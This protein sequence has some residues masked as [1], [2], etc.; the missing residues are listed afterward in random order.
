MAAS[1]EVRKP[2]VMTRDT[3]SAPAVVEKGARPSEGEDGRDGGG[4]LDH[5]GG[6]AGGAG[7][8]VDGDEVGPGGE[9]DLEIGLDVAGGELDP[10]GFAAGGL[11]QLVDL[12]PELVG[13]GD[14]G[15]V[16]RAD[17]VAAGGKA[18]DGGDL[19]GDLRTGEV[20][21]E[22]GFGR[23]AD[24]DLHRIDRPEVLRRD[25]VAVGDVLEDVA[26]G[27]LEALGQNAALAGTHGGAGGGAAAGE[28]DLDLAGQG[29]VGHV[30][31][32]D[33]GLDDQGSRRRWVR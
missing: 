7:A 4:V 1:A 13:V 15:K 26:V 5:L 3:P 6:G 23:L 21:A 27:R 17:D 2:P 20:A 30:A 29:A 24:L 12:G 8:A 19:G 25:R 14:V 10:D 31:D 11:A 28:G 9:G 33:R 22:P 18:A 16:R 32:I